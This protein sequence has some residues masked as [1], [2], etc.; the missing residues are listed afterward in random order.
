MMR[1]F[2][3]IYPSQNVVKDLHNETDSLLH[4]LIM[5]QYTN[6]SKPLCTL[7]YGGGGIM[8]LTSG[9]LV[10]CNARIN[11]VTYRDRLLNRGILFLRQLER[12]KKH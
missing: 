10:L 9:D 5:A 2:H 6:E 11:I 8:D 3:K 1:R 7:P 12:L 4:Q